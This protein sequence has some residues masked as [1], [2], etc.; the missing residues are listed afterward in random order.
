[1]GDGLNVK[2]EV[3]YVRQQKGHSIILHLLL[4]V[5]VLWINVIF[6]SASKNHYWHA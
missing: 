1:M 5:F 2:N 4:G 6:I 3:T